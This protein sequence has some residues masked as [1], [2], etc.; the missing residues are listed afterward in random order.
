MAPVLEARTD[1]QNRRGNYLPVF[2][3][4]PPDFDNKDLIQVLEALKRTQVDGVILTNTTLGREGLRSNFR[5]E[6]GGLSGA[7]LTTKAEDCLRIAID[8]LESTL[9]IISVGGVMSGEDAQRRLELGA[10]LVQVY[11]G[12]IY[13]GPGLVRAAIRMTR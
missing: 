12:L 7:P 5:E 1:L 6:S 2:V 11:T 9:P 8:T 10:Q 4:L 13:R 3:K